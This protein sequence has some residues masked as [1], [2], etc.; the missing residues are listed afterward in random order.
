[1]TSSLLT[2]P[3]LTHLKDL[4]TSLGLYEHAQIN[5][6]RTAHGYCVDDVARGLVLLCHESELDNDCELLIDVYLDFVLKAITSKGLCHNRMDDSGNWADDASTSDCW[7]RAVWALGVAA[8]H[9]PTPKQ[10][11]KSLVGFL[12]LAK[13]STRDLMSLTFAALGA[14]EVLLAY[15][16]ESRARKI[17]LAAQSRLLP[18]DETAEWVW[19]EPRLR[20]SNGSIVQAVLL[21]G[22]ALK[23]PSTIKTG[24]RMLDFLIKVETFQDHFSVTP[25]GGRGP[26]DGK[27]AFDQQPIEL[28]A[29]ASACAQA[30]EITGDA[31]WLVEIERAWG[32]FLG[33]NDV[34]SLMFVPETGGGYDGL[35]LR[36][37]NLNQGAESTISMLTTAQHAF[38]LFSHRTFS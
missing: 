4:S 6:P 34:G 22:L 11:S 21:A 18:I 1:M 2:K 33:S 8:V 7:G 32:W 38:R 17:V 16:Q 36:G 35:H 31:K 12:T 5:V 29:I 25:V 15:P 26:R 23:D 37:P 30:W 9:A 20:Y 10:R 13:N 24:I 3:P 28:A 14:G 27:S 19:P